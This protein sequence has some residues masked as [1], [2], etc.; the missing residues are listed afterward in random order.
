LEEEF[1]DDAE[2]EEGTEEDP[3]DHYPAEATPTPWLDPADRVS[4]T[5]SAFAV[6][7]PSTSLGAKPAVGFMPADHD[8]IP[9]LFS[10]NAASIFM[11]SVSA[12]RTKVPF[13]PV[14]I[15]QSSLG[16]LGTDPDSLQVQAIVSDPTN[17]EREGYL[18]GAV[19]VL[20]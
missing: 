8:D 6:P 4:V 17:G 2:E 1:E 11:V 10:A 3:S 7:S 15:V 19:K 18:T 9:E 16:A 20:F 12:N 14:D 5:R 13:L